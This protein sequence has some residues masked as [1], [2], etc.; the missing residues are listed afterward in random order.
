M[1]DDVFAGRYFA[2]F[3]AM[4][5]A[6]ALAVMSP[7]PDFAVVSR[8][9]VRHGSRIATWVSAGI[10]TGI[11]VH[12]T[13]S[14]LGLALVINQTPWLYQMLL[15]I[16]SAYFFWLGWNALRS[17]PI[18]V[19]RAAESGDGEQTV[20]VVPQI[21]VGR[22]FVIGFLTNGLNIKAT[23]FFLALFTSIIS[24]QTPLLVKVGYGTYLAIAT[25]AWFAALSFMIGKTRIRTILLSHGYWFDRV[26]G[27][28]LWLLAIH[29]LWQW[30]QYP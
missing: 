25:F 22:A 27:L 10:G 30:W 13:Y 26:M 5:I 21:S 3:L 15:L 11:L 19:S 2:E 4:A 16:A 12:V 6:H 20:A 8:Y 14:I 23:M 17:A 24:V 18:P 1:L 28:V 9:S 7:G 29:L